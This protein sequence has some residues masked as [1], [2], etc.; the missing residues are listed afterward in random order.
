MKKIFTLIILISVALLT[1]AQ[2]KK[3]LVSGSYSRSSLSFHIIQFKGNNMLSLPY[4][5]SNVIP[6]RFDDNSIEK[7]VLES[8][9]NFEQANAINI[10]SFVVTERV[11][12]Q[13][14]WNMLYDNSLGYMTFDKL[15]KRGE[16]NASDNE[17][18][19]AL[20]STR[21]AEAIRESGAE[22]LKNIYFIVYY[23][24]SYASKKMDK[25]SEELTYSLSGKSILYKLDIDSVVNNGQFWSE[26]FFDKK[27]SQKSQRFMQYAFKVKP[28]LSASIGSVSSDREIKIDLKGVKT[29]RSYSNQEIHDN[30]YST[31]LNESV[32]YFSDNYTAFKI[33]VPIIA[34]SP[35]QAKIGKKE[36]LKIDDLYQVYENRIDP[37]DGEKFSQLMGHVRV[38]KVADNAK[39]ADGNTLP[40][41]FYRAPI[42][43]VKTGMTLVENRDDLIFGLSYNTGNTALSGGYLNID[44]ITRTF[45]GARLGLD[46]GFAP[47]IES[48]KW[49]SGLGQEYTNAKI[50]GN[51]VNAALSFKKILS[52]NY[53]EITPQIG[54]YGSSITQKEATIAGTKYKV[55]A[56]IE[57]DLSIPDAKDY[58][59]QTTTYG[60]MGGVSFGLNLGLYLQLNVGYKYGYEIGTETNLKDADD[61]KV[62]GYTDKISYKAEAISFGIRIK[63]F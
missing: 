6:S 31:I 29:V 54:M 45:P 4:N 26:L 14:L 63:G 57:D 10:D 39:N 50:S 58:S 40:S 55:K 23:P 3:K 22:L 53:F 56:L 7:I 51:A 5:G 2:D 46:L 36:G 17:V 34:K 27:D 35:I 20:S 1:N 52:F 32:E 38:R 41:T 16:Y 47:T 12:N 13:I 37:K 43:V 19:Q 30:L 61:K 8:S 33:S 24:I 18:L 21:G 49:S 28:V 59:L 9:A 25:N 15:A 48:N 60:A 11:P 42:K 44:Y 62:A